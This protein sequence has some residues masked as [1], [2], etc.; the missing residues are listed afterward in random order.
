M[1]IKLV[2][3]LHITATQKR[4][5]AQLLKAG[6][7]PGQG[8]GSGKFHYKFEAIDWDKKTATVT[9]GYMDSNDYGKKYWRQFKVS[10]T[11]KE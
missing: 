4:H 10:I 8:G 3:G 1:Q 5:I 11:Y 6:I 9:I 7:E 2:D